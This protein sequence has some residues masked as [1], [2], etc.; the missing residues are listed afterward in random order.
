MTTRPVPSYSQRPD[1]TDHSLGMSESEQAL[2]GTSQV[3]LFW[4]EDQKECDLYLN[5]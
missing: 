2:K 4:S 3:K 1:F 5:C